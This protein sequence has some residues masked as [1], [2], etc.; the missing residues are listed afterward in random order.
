[1]DVSERCGSR[2]ERKSGVRRFTL[3]Y[4]PKMLRT[5]HHVTAKVLVAIMLAS[6]LLLVSH[7]PAGAAAKP[8]AAK[9]AHFKRCAKGTSAYAP[10]EYLRVKKVSCKVARKVIRRTVALHKKS[11]RIR[12]F[13][14]RY[15]VTKVPDGYYRAKWPKQPGSYARCSK[16]RKQIKWADY[17]E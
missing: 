1:M 3:G 5:A 13:S 16:G 12:G 2:L 17:N 6:G 11:A 8:E 4:A 10:A 7:S 9:G 15:H 14:C